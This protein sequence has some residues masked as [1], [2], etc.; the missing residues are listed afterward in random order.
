MSDTKPSSSD[1]KLIMQLY[2]LRR[3]AEMRKARQWFGEKFWPESFEEFIKVAFDFGSQESAWLRQVGSYWEMAASFVAR[4]VLDPGLFYDNCGEM[5]FVYVKVKPFIAKM[6]QAV[7]SN[8]FMANVERVAEG[9][10]EGRARVQRMLQNFERMK[11]LRV[12]AK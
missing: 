5:W 4:G 1:A 3:E 11:Q 12:G 10:P 2:D 7:G 8:E 9:T 6:R